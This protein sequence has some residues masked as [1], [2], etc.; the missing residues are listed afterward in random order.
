MTAG[1]AISTDS[2]SDHCTASNI[3]LWCRRGGQRGSDFA[4]CFRGI[5]VVLVDVHRHAFPITA[6][7]RP[8]RGRRFRGTLLRFRFRYPAGVDPLVRD[9]L[10]HVGGL[11]GAVLT[12]G[13]VRAS[14]LNGLPP[15]HGRVHRRCEMPKCRSEVSFAVEAGPILGVAGKQR[16]LTSS[17]KTG[18]APNLIVLQ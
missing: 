8:F 7:A 2:R 18:T 6:S 13:S 17:S 1:A 5:G 16:E 9:R 4:C 14:V 12:A 3:R 10:G 15:C 11:A